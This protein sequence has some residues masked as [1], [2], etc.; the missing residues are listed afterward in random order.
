MD[1][2]QAAKNI[3]EA[4]K[5]LNHNSPESNE[6]INWTYTPDI[7]LSDYLNALKCYLKKEKP[8]ASERQKA[9]YLLEEILTLSFKGLAGYSE[10]KS[11]QS[12][13]HQYD[14][15]IS[16][17][18]ANWDI[19]CNRLFLENYRGIVVEAKAT[20]EVVSIAQFSRLCSVLSLE[21]FNTVGL[22]VFFTLKGAAGFPSRNGRKKC[23]SDARLC[24]LL[25]YARHKKNI[26]VFDKDDIFEL[27][28]NGALIH[29]LIRK[30]KEI[31]QSSGLK[32]A[33]VAELVD[34]D[35]P[36]RL[37]NLI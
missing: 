31:E 6:V 3:I 8:T 35:L 18:G 15:L 26:V 37:K 9:G 20:E 7:R 14:F 11:Y 1:S 33:P 23:I 4:L 29:I 5:Y 13:S 22:G 12:S 21:L 17:D 28:E 16:G 30:I 34:I 25:F 19:I 27:N 36:E 2:K 32:N 10:I 24:Q